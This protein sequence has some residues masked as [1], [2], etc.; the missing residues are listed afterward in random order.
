VKRGRYVYDFPRPALTVDV[1]AVTFSDGRLKVVLVERGI[2]PFKGMWVL[3]GG[4]VGVEEPLQRAAKRELAEETGLR[5]RRVEPFGVFG[6]PGRD[7]RGRTVS[8]AFLGLVRGSPEVAGGD[9]AARAAWFDFYRPGKKLGFDHGLILRGARK[10]L[11]E[12]ALLDGDLLGL[13]PEKFSPKEAAALYGL[14][15][16][17]SVAPAELAARLCRAGLARRAGRNL[18]RRTRARKLYCSLKSGQ[19]LKVDSQPG[20]TV[21]Q[22]ARTW[23]KDGGSSARH[24]RRK[25]RWR[26]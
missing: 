2:E 19:R 5:L 13:L 17:G 15:L 16:G 6:A 8:A 10:R 12:K 26:P 24:S 4:F 23:A 3:P 22:E 11:R 18:L 9:D 21:N 25:W 1:V 7:P 20:Y 14:V